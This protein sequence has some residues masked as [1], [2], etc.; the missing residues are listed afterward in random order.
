[1]ERH[2]VLRL[3]NSSMPPVQRVPPVQR[4]D[5]SGKL[6]GLPIIVPRMS[7]QEAYKNSKPT[8]KI[9]SAPDPDYSSDSKELDSPIRRRPNV[10]QRPGVETLEDS[11][12]VSVGFP[13][14]DTAS[15]TATNKSRTRIV[16]PLQHGTG[17]T[18][19]AKPSSHVNLKRYLIDMQGWKTVEYQAFEVS[20][21]DLI[22]AE[23]Y[24][25]IKQDIVKTI[26]QKLPPVNYRQQDKKAFKNA[27]IEVSQA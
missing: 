16:S 22:A 5:F 11:D 23:T 8:G 2:K 25:S 21:E 1:M 24:Q 27:C 6:D 3:P 19:I 26:A 20:L 15:F 12:Y 10:S 9:F 13:E 18:Q 4:M 7:F 14:D 17:S